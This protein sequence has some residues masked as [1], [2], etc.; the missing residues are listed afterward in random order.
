MKADSIC[1]IHSLGM[2]ILLEKGKDTHRDHLCNYSSG[3]L[4]VQILPF[5]L[6]VLSISFDMEARKEC[7]AQHS[8]LCEGNGRCCRNRTDYGNNRSHRQQKK[9]RRKQSQL[10]KKWTRKWI[11]GWEET[12]CNKHLSRSHWK[13]M[14]GNST[15]GNRQRRVNLN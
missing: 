9:A 12:P 7:R 13:W 11:K 5:K 10:T 14:E 3:V 2:N 8:L 1:T 15:S 4:W 6:L